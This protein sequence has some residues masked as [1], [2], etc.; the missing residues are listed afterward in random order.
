M[1][2]SIKE[3]ITQC[4][5]ELT[6]VRQHIDARFYTR[7]MNLVHQ[8]NAT[9][10]RDYELRIVQLILERSTEEMATPN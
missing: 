6:A 9:G 5:R 8:Y 2:N 1:P 3:Q 4:A 10:D 7:F